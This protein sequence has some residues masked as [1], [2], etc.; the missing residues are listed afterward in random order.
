M[1]RFQV[2]LLVLEP[3]DWS[4]ERM[5]RQMGSKYEGIRLWEKLQAFEGERVDPDLVWK[6]AQCHPNHASKVYREPKSDVFTALGETL[7]NQKVVDLIEELEPGVHQ[8][9]PFELLDRNGKPWREPYFM[10]NVCNRVDAVVGEESDL[11]VPV[12]LKDDP[13]WRYDGGGKH[14][15]FR[16]E[17]IEGM[18]IW[19][20]IR[21]RKKNLCSDAFWNEF[22][23]RGLT[24]MEART[25]RPII[26]VV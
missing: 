24:G 16:G 21:L 19:S 1:E 17:A 25:D 11:E 7:V 14:W 15:T 10:L 3:E 23:G 13:G 8:F 5:R 22:K 26:T 18:A 9:L 20:D 6:V 12:F 2:P 4:A